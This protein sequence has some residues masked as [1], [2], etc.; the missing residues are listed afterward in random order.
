MIKASAGELSDAVG[1]QALERIAELY[2]I[3]KEIRGRSPEERR[4]VR[5]ARSRPLL[6][7]LKQWFDD[8]LGKFET[9]AWQ[10]YNELG[11]VQDEEIPGGSGNME[12]TAALL[13]LDADM[14]QYLHDQTED[15][16]THFQF[17]DAY[18][19]RRAQ[20]ASI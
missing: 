12:Y 14:P 17:I 1:Q 6:E 10:Q 16:M 15:S 11:G 20:R 18:L 5:L 19:P 2:A 3:E 8:T 4:E 13:V 7:S 9:D